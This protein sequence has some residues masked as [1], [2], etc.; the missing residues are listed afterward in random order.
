MKVEI[1]FGQQTDLNLQ[2]KIKILVNVIGNTFT[3]S[4][5][6]KISQTGHNLY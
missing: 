5:K 2:T 3:T 4:G 1:H 6:A